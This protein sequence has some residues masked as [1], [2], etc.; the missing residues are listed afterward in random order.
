MGDPMCLPTFHKVDLGSEDDIARLYGEMQVY[1][2]NWDQPFWF[3][4]QA[5]VNYFQHC[6]IPS[7]EFEAMIRPNLFSSFLLCKLGVPYMMS[8]N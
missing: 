7:E 5:I 4:T 2:V 8:Q 3:R 6:C 1:M